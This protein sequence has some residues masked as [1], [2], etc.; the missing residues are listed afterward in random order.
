MAIFDEQVLEPFSARG[1]GGS[2]IASRQIQAENLPDL[3]AAVRQSQLTQQNLAD[4]QKAALAALAV[5]NYKAPSIR[6]AV[7]DVAKFDPTKPSAAFVSTK[8]PSTQGVPTQG[9]R[10]GITATTNNDQSVT[11][12]FMD[13]AD[14]IEYVK[15]LQRRGL[16]VAIPGL[17]DGLTP[18]EALQLQKLGVFNI[19][20]SGLLQ[21]M[22]GV[23]KRKGVFEQLEARAPNR[24]DKVDIGKLKPSPSSIIDAQNLN[25]RQND[26]RLT[27]GF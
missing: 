20:D 19:S 6:G 25:N 2:G 17:Q 16:Q 22:F 26:Y 1:L 23:S 12:E 15:E 14:A 24:F 18:E 11:K 5:K 27:G 21:N 8:A 10:F 3:S 4:Q 13:F 9:K 7:R